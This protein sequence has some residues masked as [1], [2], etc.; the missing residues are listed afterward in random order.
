[1]SW[2]EILDRWSLVTIDFTEAYGVMVDDLRERPWPVVR[3][4]ILGLLTRDSRLSRD[5]RA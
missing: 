1:M 4:H 5:L 2:R 3:D